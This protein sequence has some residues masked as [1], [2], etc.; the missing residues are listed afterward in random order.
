MFDSNEVVE[1]SETACAPL[2]EA[3]YAFD[4]YVD[5]QPFFA[6]RTLSSVV[7][8]PLCPSLQE[9]IHEIETFDPAAAPWRAMES[10]EPETERSHIEDVHVELDPE[11]APIP[12]TPEQDFDMP[13]P[14]NDWSDTN[15]PV[16]PADPIN[17]TNPVYQMEPAQ[18]ETSQEISQEAAQ[19]REIETM[20]RNTPPTDYRYFVPSRVTKSWA[21]PSHWQISKS[22][23]SKTKRAA[24]KTQ[25]KRK[26]VI[27]F[28]SETTK[29]SEF[30]TV[31]RMA[32][33]TINDTAFE[34]QSEHTLPDDH[35]ISF[36]S[37]TRLFC[38]DDIVLHRLVSINTSAASG[39]TP[40]QWEVSPENVDVGGCS[41]ENPMD[42]LNTQSEESVEEGNDPLDMSIGNGD[43]P[44]EPSHVGFISEINDSGESW[45]FGLTGSCGRKPG[46]GLAAPGRSRRGES[47]NQLR[48]QGDAGGRP[49]AESGGVVSSSRVEGDMEGDGGASRERGVGYAEE[50]HQGAERAR[51][52]R[53]AGAVLLHLPVAH[54]L[55]D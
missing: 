54:I 2:P 25:S 35:H 13:L 21:G 7:S 42:I 9:L 55:S 1:I 22:A 43:E 4:S 51:L 19:R 37:L 20:I 39:L 5:P 38:R 34:S 36:E 17:P 12:V 10:E 29:P 24:E 44:S 53:H 6:D 26:Q 11:M 27:S 45:R 31:K 41:L 49:A 23:K 30:V 46:A 52:Q 32:D 48:E 33:L 18:G 3:D 28:A 8:K 14:D 47:G 15:D 50:R 16:E 40:D